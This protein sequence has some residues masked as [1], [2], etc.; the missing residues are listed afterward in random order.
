MR[1]AWLAIGLLAIP[2]PAA[3]AEK[4]SVLFCSPQGVTAGWLDLEYLK[5]LHA[6]G[7]EVDYTDD[8][9]E[10]TAER[11]KRY[12][13]LVIFTTPDAFDVTTR[14]MKSS[15][16]K[17]RQ[18][19]QMI[20]GY[21]ASGGGV[22][23]MPTECNMLKQ[24]VS[25]LT[26]LWGAKIPVELIE[27]KDPAKRGYLTHASQQVPLAWTDRVLPGPVS[28]GVRQ[29]WYPIAP[30]Y[31]AQM[32][33]G[34]IL[35][36]AW[37]PVVRCSK[38]A[39]TKPIDLAKSTMP[40][41][42]RPHFRPATS[43]P[44]FFAV[45]GYQ[46]GRI[47]L[48]NQWR[49]F[50]FGSGTRLIFSRQ[51]LSAGVGDRPSDF[52]KLLENTLRWLAGPNAPGGYAAPPD[53]F[54]PPN[55]S[56][57]VRNDYADQFW[58]Y[59]PAA[60][61]NAAPAPH[62][63][64][65]R[66]L[67]GAR[68]TYST[69]R[70]T[71]PEYA[72]AAAAAGL[73]FLVFL[74]DFTKLDPAKLQHL[75]DECRQH[76]TPTLRLLPG[77]TIRNNIGNRM[78]FFGPDPAWIPDYCLTGPDKK[79]LYIQEQD[80]Q[81]KFTG[82]ITPFLDWV[83]NAYHVEKGQ[84]GYYDF[85][86]SP[87]GMRLPDLRLYGMAGVRYYRDGKLVEDNT[88]A[89]LTTAACT[90]PPA[91]ASVN[92]VADAAELAREVQS[93][94]A[95][96]YA[97]ASG[98]GRV[99]E[100]SLRWTHQYDAPNVS[101]SDG[102]RVLAWPNCYRVWALGAEE[103]VTGRTVMPSPLAVVSDRG[104][105]EIRLYNGPVLYRRFLPGGAKEFR[106]TLVLEGSIQKN[107]VMV[108]EDLDGRRAVTFARRCWRDGGLAVSFCSDHVNDGTMALA[109]GPY[110]YQW[111][112]QPSLPSDVAGD[113]WDGGPLAM[114]P[115]VT[116]QQTP[117]TLD[118]DKGK[119]DGN[120]FDQIP[121]LE[122]SDD[123]ALAV[124]SVRREVFDDSLL[125]VV[126]PWHTYGPIGGPSRLFEYVQRYREYVPPTVGYPQTGWAA[127]GVREGTNAALFRQE[128][129]FKDDL[130]IKQ[131]SLGYFH[132]KPE[133][134]LV[135]RCNGKTT[136]HD[137]GQA[138]DESFSLRPGDWF[139][140]F[141]TK[142]ANS[143]L[144]FIRGEPVRMDRR[145][146]VLFFFAERPAVKKGERVVFEA[147]SIG[148]PLNVPIASQ[149]DLE[150]YAAYLAA[151]DGMQILRGK[152]LERAG[153][154]DLAPDG[155]FAMELS[156]PRPRQ[157]LKLTLPVRV[158]GLNPRWSAGLLQRQ[159]YV[160]G[161]YGT[162]ENRYRPVGLDLAGTTY[163]PLY[164]DWAERTHVVVGH[165]IVAG[166]EGKELFIQVT[167]VAD[168]P[169]RWHVSVNNPTDTV[170]KTVLRRGMPLPGL[171]FPDRALD[172]PAGGYVVLQ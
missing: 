152:R 112:R 163:V 40:V 50:S 30:A 153:L 116:S 172:L 139:G 19:A 91:P 9:A 49:Q 77:F 117:P 16:E 78:F 136:L 170:I 130:A 103:F 38:T 20:D 106:Q 143:N 111:I 138:K 124:S 64:L 54:Q 32:T 18:F 84:V 17:A 79:T 94:H 33:G 59:D 58:P 125:N 135:V 15:P 123:G 7:F 154:L 161:H 39:V 2:L 42:D 95:L 51:V 151:P 158:E 127:P 27:E 146:T 115:L 6:K 107:L 141:S 104:L 162:G 159:G 56:P 98:L 74:E 99:F 45:R 145:G 164:P 105:R 48:V 168:Q 169:P 43:E 160:K 83:L 34:L 21:A 70:G 126:N 156:L 155:D 121:M 96:V 67:I 81:G 87:K 61:G 140:T 86:G 148:F 100:E 62:L 110:H 76:S 44:V 8:L 46:K 167:K 133:A 10:V 57:K 165:P 68:T 4:P 118:S 24:Q 80:G 47:A 72:R 93:G 113:T 88:E 3:A 109:H 89:F 52:G 28:E 36:D 114:L 53:R 171:E 150:R 35:D 63:K 26:D 92:E 108:A 120:R 97:Q 122:Y 12:N 13:V 102:P 5:E 157:S 71:V 65:F 119:E 75:R 11:I 14:G 85:S 23:L 55:A 73:D 131:L 144:F 31:N 137:L 25:D 90:I 29:V 1:Y 41:L 60:L 147:A 129:A 22:L 128:I 37:Q 69:G 142:P 66:G 149:A 82:Y 132:L 134:Q 101:V 166:P